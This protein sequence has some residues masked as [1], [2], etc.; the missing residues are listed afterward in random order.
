[1]L[2]SASSAQPN[3]SESSS[4]FTSVV[5]TASVTRLDVTGINSSGDELT[6]GCRCFHRGVPHAEEHLEIVQRGVRPVGDLWVLAH[7]VQQP[8]RRVD[9]HA[10]VNACDVA[11]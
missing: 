7:R 4:I 10:A 3:A 11:E 6:R 1:M 9:V 5:M 8:Q 2:S